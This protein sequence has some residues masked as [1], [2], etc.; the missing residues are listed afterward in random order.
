MLSD[1]DYPAVKQS[2]NKT[3]LDY[4]EKAKQDRFNNMQSNTEINFKNMIDIKFISNDLNYGDWILSY[5]SATAADD[6]KE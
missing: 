1:A 5:A 4:T 6:L 2:E 3:L